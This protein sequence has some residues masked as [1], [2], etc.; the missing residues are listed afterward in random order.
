MKSILIAL[1]LVVTIHS[2]QAQ[3]KEKDLPM[4]I[5]TLIKNNYPKAEDLEWSKAHSNTYN[6]VVYNI[7]FYVNERVVSMEM[8]AEG[9]VLAK[10]TELG[11]KDL[12][13]SLQYFIQQH[14]IKFAA[15]VEYHDDKP[16]YVL[17]TV[18]KGQSHFSVFN[19][20][21]TLIHTKKNFSL[22]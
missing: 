11:I 10:E 20:N 9:L 6:A 21:G 1:L 3:S 13:R 5:D 22:F 8:T 15:L 16:V 17:E 19:T 4:A 18:Y 14:K 7:H 12:P 2:V